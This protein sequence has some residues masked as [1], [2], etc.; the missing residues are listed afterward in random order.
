MR[1]RLLSAVILLTLLLTGV[2]APE[3]AYACDPVYHTVRP[4]ENLTQIANYYGVTVQAIVNANTLWNPNVIYV[5]QY[6]RIPVPCQPS[7]PPNQCTQIH[8]VKRGEYLKVIAKRYGTTWK[9]IADMNHLKNPNLIWT[10][11]RLKVPAP[12]T[13]PGP[14]PSPTPP[15]QQTGNWKGQYWNNRLLSGEPKFVKYT[16]VIDYNWGKNGPGDGIG[17]TNFSARWTRARYFDEGSYRFYVKVDDGVRVWLN[18]VLIIDKWHDSPPTTYTFDS[19]L[20][21]GIHN[22]QVD[23]Y[24]NQGGAQIKFWIEPLGSTAAW[25]GVYFNNANLSGSPVKSQQYSAIDFDWGKN[26][27]IAGVTADYFSARFTGEFHFTGGKY[28]F[29]VTADDGIRVWMD[30]NLILDKWTVT[31]AKTYHLDVD[32]GEGNHKLKV[33]YFEDKGAAVCKVR[34]SK[35]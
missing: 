4:G 19:Q 31:A 20:S 6:L 5:G 35:K 9:V 7:P 23:Y 32:I 11:Q 12:C 26:S 34:W 16:N 1:F 15:P 8:V 25:T 22:L 14:K 10:G 2:A 33:E 3:A 24:Q 29:T 18:S 21:A 28:H 30:D 13:G 17:G 27:P